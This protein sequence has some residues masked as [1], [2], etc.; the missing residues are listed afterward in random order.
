A[1][2]TVRGGTADGIYPFDRFRRIEVSGG[3][4]QLREEYNDPLL[5]QLAGQYQTTPISQGGLGLTTA[6]FNT[7]TL[8]PFGVALVQETTVFREYGP[9]AGSTFRLAYDVAPKIGNTLSRQAVDADGRHY[10]RIAGS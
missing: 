10:L 6:V 8:V 2:R 7:G 5:Q 1:R 9:L 4:V 3:I